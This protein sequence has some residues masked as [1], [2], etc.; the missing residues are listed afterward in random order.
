MKPNFLQ[1]EKFGWYCRCRRSHWDSIHRAGL[2]RNAFISYYHRR[3]AEV[4]PF[5]IFPGSRVLEV[6][7]GNGRLLGSLD[8]EKG[9]GIDFSEEAIRQANRQ[10]AHR[11]DLLF[12]C[13]EA[14]ALPLKP[15]GT[16]DFIILSD[17]MN[18]LW[19]VQYFLTRLREYAGPQTRLIINLYSNVWAP[20]LK[21]AQKMGLT[22]KLLEQN[23]LTVEDLSHL[24]HLADWETGETWSEILLPIEGPKPFQWINQVLAKLKPF[25]FGCLTNFLLARPQWKRLPGDSSPAVSIIVPA[26]NEAGNIPA[27]FSRL[28]K[29]GAEM[30]LILV[31]GNSTD[32]TRE[33]ILHEMSRHPEVNASFYVQEASGKGDAV[34]KGFAHAKGDVLMILDADLTVAPEDLPRFYQALVEGKGEFINGVRLVYPMEKE[35]MKFFNLVGNKFFSLGFSWVLRQPIKDVLCGTKVL[36]K[37]DYQRIAANR[38]YFGNFDPFGDFDLLFGAAKLNLKIV[39]LPVRYQERVYGSTNIERWRHGWMLLKMLLFG[40]RRLRFF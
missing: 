1:N 32:T 5:H 6:G 27:L 22:Q 7:C 11:A 20:I 3:L 13:G 37:S 17:V 19:D 12:I 14:H 8:L 39:D 40:A 10:F 25:S 21:M 29:F 26:R 23:W 36:W 38:P 16:F 18:D 15:E 2:V 31:E 34:R 35:A 30:E 9:V 28:P 4:F 24:L 33:A